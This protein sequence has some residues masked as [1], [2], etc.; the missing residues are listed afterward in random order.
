[1]PFDFKYMF[2]PIIDFLEVGKD[3]T[4]HY[5]FIRCQDVLLG[6]FLL[7]GGLLMLCFSVVLLLTGRF[8]GGIVMGSAGLAAVILYVISRKQG[9]Y[10]TYS[11]WLTCIGMALTILGLTITG[12][13]LLA[14]FLCVIFPVVACILFL[15]KRGSIMSII[16]LAAYFG[17]ELFFDKSPDLW[18]L[19][20]ASLFAGFIILIAVCTFLAANEELLNANAHKISDFQKE[21]EIKNEFISQLSHQIRTPL[22]NIVVIGNLLNDTQLN[23]RQK[24]WMETILAS[25]NNLVNVVN[26]IASKVASTGIV[27]AKPTN[28]TFNLQT[29]LNN[30]VQLFV[31][32]SDEYNIALKP[33]LE[34]PYNLEGDPIQ[35]KQIFLTL[36]DAIIK[37]KKAQKINIIIS[38]RVK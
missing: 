33:N 16:M 14:S 1:M 11:P 29:V 35:I 32:Q 9:K 28:I 34:A 36:I 22:N 31:G 23:L 26:I 20:I 30:T 37:N 12:N 7:I 10:G 17:C 5:W 24:D 18:Y 21:T 15:A 13:G 38:Y 2:K 27:D 4:V 3:K 6:V 25:A 19:L 8:Y